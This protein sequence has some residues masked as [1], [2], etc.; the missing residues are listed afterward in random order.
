MQRFAIY[1]KI[2]SRYSVVRLYYYYYYYYYYY[3]A[4][5]GLSRLVVAS[6]FY[7]KKSL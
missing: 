6:V 5:I 7:P 4:A 1:L 2:S 3:G